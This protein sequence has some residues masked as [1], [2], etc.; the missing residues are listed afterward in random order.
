M[1]NTL[2]NL[3]IDSGLSEYAFAKKVGISPQ[4]LGKQKKSKKTFNLSV[5]YAKILGI[6]R[7]HGIEEKMEIDLI[8]K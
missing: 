5:K 2:E 1:K 6:Q 4:S 7:I 3:I 8:L